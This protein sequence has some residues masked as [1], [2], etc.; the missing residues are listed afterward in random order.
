LHI[1]LFILYSLGC[2]FAIKKL[3]F[4][5][6]SGIRT[7]VLLVFFAVHVLTGCLHNVIA[8]RYYPGHGDIWYYFED[9]ADQ[10]HKLRT[11]FQTFVRDNGTLDSFSHN[12]LSFIHVFLNLFSLRNM[13]INTLL[14]SFPVFLGTTALFRVFRRHFPDGG[15]AALSVYLLPSVLF[16][17]SCLHREGAL[18]ML[19]GFFFYQLD[20]R[21]PGYSL[22]F[23]L[24][25]AYFRVGVALPLIPALAVMYY[26]PR[27]KKLFIAG[28]LGAILVIGLTGP[29]LLKILE[30]QQQAF[31]T[32]EGHS[33]IFLPVLDGTIGN[34][35]LAL[36]TA[37]LNG[38]LEPLP[39]VG[40]QTIYG[41]FSLE[42]LLIW[43]VVI[44]AGIRLLSGI[45][46]PAAG[47]AFFLFA[48]LGMLLVGLIVPFVGA[49]VRYRS[50]YLPFLLAPALFYLR[51][52]APFRRANDYLNR[53][54]FHRL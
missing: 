32:L 16:W 54:L 34:F 28:A 8:W 36:P 23:F 51:D 30:H 53:L 17:T 31:Q 42:L 12:S 49:I 5:R 41:A 25:I 48:L 52:W 38:W 7:G 37:L 24:L 21:A 1:L 43:A 50:I 13:Y 27:R 3:R 39:G 20:R 15:L 14:F 9:A 40:G 45:R 2:A 33:R 44:F 47:T 46:R 11:D 29:L 10:V 26:H 35:L 22:L 6:E 4:F 18:Y 19:L